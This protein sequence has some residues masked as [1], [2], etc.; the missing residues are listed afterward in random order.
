MLYETSSQNILGFQVLE[1]RYFIIEA[2]V[3]YAG[4]STLPKCQSTLLA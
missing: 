4:A 1:L 3:S 2:V